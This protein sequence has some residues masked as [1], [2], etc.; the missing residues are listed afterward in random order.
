[1]KSLKNLKY[2]L[3]FHSFNKKLPINSK[4]LIKPI[5]YSQSFINTTSPKS[6]NNDKSINYNSFDS[7]NVSKILNKIINQKTQKKLKY[8]KNSELNYIFKN[9]EI[10]SYDYNL[11]D[12]TIKKS[13]STLLNKINKIHLKKQYKTNTSRYSSSINSILNANLKN[14][15]LNY[16]TERD[17]KKRISFKRFS[18][19]AIFGLKI[20]EPSDVLEEHIDSKLKIKNKFA[21]FKLMLKKQK[22]KNIQ[23]L[24]NLHKTRILNENIL[25]KSIYEYRHK[26][27]L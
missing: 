4:I 22:E 9:K 27:N 26:Q 16:F 13:S 20:T 5:D 25:K 12:N 14:Q 10:Y 21:K 23:L 3:N 8:I 18:N 24:Y 2:R 6:I 1:M 15:C 7:K 11:D 19:S 17:S